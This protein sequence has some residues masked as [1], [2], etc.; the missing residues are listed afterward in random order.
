MADPIQQMNELKAQN[1]QSVSTTLNL[2]AQNQLNNKNNEILVKQD[3][4]A[5]FRND[6]LNKKLDELNELEHNIINKDRL[7]EQTNQINQNKDKNIYTLYVGLFLSVVLF[8]IILLYSLEK[9]N[10][11]LATILISIVFILFLLIV[12]YNYNIAHFATLVNFFKNRRELKIEAS[13][14]NFGSR[15][16]SWAQERAYG[17]KQEWIDNNCACPDS[18]GTYSDEENTSVEIKPGYFYYDK[19]AP[20]QNIHPDGG[21]KINV[22]VNPNKKI[23]DKIHWVNHDNVSNNMDNNH[24]YNIEPNNYDMYK[25][26]KLVGDSTYTVN[27]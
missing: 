17:N 22:S 1:Q 5:K 16:T 4:L 11:K 27:L 12:L 15:I 25:E 8:I 7:I 23:Y 26:G 20:K 3:Q 19:N 14:G 10:N 21:D 2:V 18:E 24:E 6:K 13:I 9:I